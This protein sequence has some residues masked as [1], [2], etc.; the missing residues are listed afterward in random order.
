MGL[1]ISSLLGKLFGNQ[2]RRILMGTWYAGLCGSCLWHLN[3]WPIGDLSL[4]LLDVWYC[5]T[6]TMSVRATWLLF[7]NMRD[8]GKTCW[9]CALLTSWFM[10]WLTSRS[11]C[12]GK[13]NDSVQTEAG[14]DRDHDSNNRIQCGDSW[15]QEHQLYCVG[16]WRYV[17]LCCITLVI[18]AALSQCFKMILIPRYAALITTLS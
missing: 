3:S 15:I 10:L 18:L 7:R 2:E 17:L 9:F 11:W 1:T 4:H 12:C 14:W 16:C 13:N 6:H 8:R 5:F